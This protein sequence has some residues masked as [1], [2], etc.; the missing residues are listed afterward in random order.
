MELQWSSDSHVSVTHVAWC[1]SHFPE[2]TTH[3]PEA[4][5]N[6][7]LE[8]EKLCGVF[9]SPRS[10]FWD[11]IITLSATVKFSGDLAQ[12]VAS[13]LGISSTHQQAQLAAVLNQ[14]RREFENAFPRFDAE[15]Q[16]RTGPLR[17]L[18]EAQGPGLLRMMGRST[19]E[20]L[21]V[22]SAQIVPVQPIL[23]GFG[24][25]HLTTNRVHIEAVL[26]NASPE[27][28]ETLRL[29]WLLGQLDLERP[30]HSENINTNRLRSVAGLAMLPVVLT[31]GEELDVCHNSLQLMERTIELWRADTLHVQPAQAANIVSTW[32]ETYRAARPEWK[33][34]LTGLDKMLS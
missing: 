21:L 29:A 15:I 19:D 31:A 34:A 32:W 2:Q 16:L 1:I 27:L 18:W 5:R 7:A 6:A 13:R 20:Q 12:R 30:V 24:Y 14:C 26:T 22:E 11:Q 17:Q 4:L 25:A 23:G 10:R 33:V 28:P 8:L 3:C 9:Q